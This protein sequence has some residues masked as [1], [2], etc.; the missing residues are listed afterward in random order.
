[1][2]QKMHAIANL[3]LVA[4]SAQLVTQ[5]PVAKHKQMGILTHSFEQIRCPNCV[6]HAFLGPEPA[7]HPNETAARRKAQFFKKHFTRR[8]TYSAWGAGCRWG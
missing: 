6:F 1:M 2:S 8:R 4:K 3:N 7:N 5:R